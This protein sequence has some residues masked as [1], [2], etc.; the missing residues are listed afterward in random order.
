LIVDAKDDTAAA[1][2]KHFGFKRFMDA[3]LALCLPLGR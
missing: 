2:Y 3:E 1:F